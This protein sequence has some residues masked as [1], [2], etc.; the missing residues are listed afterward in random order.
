MWVILPV[1]HLHGAKNRLSEVL[2]AEQ[3]VCLS[4]L[5]LIDVMKVITSSDVVEGVIVISSDTT[6][7]DI[8][9]RYRV[10][11]VQTE[12]DAGHSADASLAVS[13][14]AE[15]DIEKVALLPSDVPLLSQSDLHDLD[16]THE[17]GITLCPAPMDGGTNGLVFSPPLEIPLRFGK[18]SL[19]KF[20][21]ESA[22]QGIEARP[23]PIQGLERDID[24]PEDLA[25]LREQPRGGQAW[26]YVR[27]LSIVTG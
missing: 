20:Q 21:Q 14:L 25:W 11:H 22:R 1:K 15:R 17:G 6:V 16:R 24:R 4:K 23:V 13:I 27:E 5:M 9:K 7:I 18:D 2:T 19:N 12:K 10:E 3:R 26:T 8:A